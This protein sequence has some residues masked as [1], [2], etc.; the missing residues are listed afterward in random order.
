MAPYAAR[1]AKVR[2]SD[3]ATISAEQEVESR[4]ETFPLPMF[5]IG[6]A[7]AQ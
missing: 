5:Q 2:P 7:I 6:P 1:A 4:S 3:E